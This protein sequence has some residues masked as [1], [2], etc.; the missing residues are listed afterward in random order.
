MISKLLKNHTG[1]DFLEPQN[2]IFRWV[3]QLTDE[4]VSEEIGFGIQ[5][6]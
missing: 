2:T 4:L 6:K 5:I 3:Q 1:Y